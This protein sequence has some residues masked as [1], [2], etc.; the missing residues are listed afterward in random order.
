MT[1]L[2]HWAGM[3]TAAG[4]GMVLGSTT[5]PAVAGR[6]QKPNGGFVAGTPEGHPG[7]GR[8][9]SSGRGAG[10]R[11][12]NPLPRNSGPPNRSTVRSNTPTPRLGGGVSRNTSPANPSRWKAPSGG[13]LGSKGVAPSNSK[14]RRSSDKPWGLGG[15]PP[16]L[17]KGNFP[18]RA[19]GNHR[20]DVAQAE[21]SILQALKSRELARQKFEHGGGFDR[22]LN[23]FR[24]HDREIKAWQR[25]RLQ[26][27]LAG[28]D[29][30]AAKDKEQANF[31]A[32]YGLEQSKYQGMQNSS[33]PIG[34]AAASSWLTDPNWQPTETKT[35]GD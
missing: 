35:A 29:S 4:L 20:R 12:T 10:P 14:R 22:D 23:D 2:S 9:D 32:T 16:Q 7:L 11:A 6:P 30:Q 33:W 17:G 27:A 3:L 1:R 5:T 24:R 8:G 13:L 25:R 26:S 28:A 18:G 21:S 15:D 19:G 31:Q 34:E